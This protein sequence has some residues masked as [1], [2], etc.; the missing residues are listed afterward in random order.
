MPDVANICQQYKILLEPIHK[1]IKPIPHE[2]TDI[3]RPIFSILNEHPWNQKSRELLK[4]DKPYYL[5]DENLHVLSLI[6]FGISSSEP[7]MIESREMINAEWWECGIQKIKN[8][9]DEFR[10]NYTPIQIMF[11][12]TTPPSETY[13]DNDLPE[14]MEAKN[15]VDGAT[16]LL[17]HLLSLME[18]N[19]EI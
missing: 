1:I 19:K 4:P 15:A 17:D 3:Y 6:H 5:D 8:K 2:L 7:E 11:Y 9:L 14:L 13:T 10:L 16:V 18:Y 12:I